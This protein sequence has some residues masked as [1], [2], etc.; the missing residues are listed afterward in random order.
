MVEAELKAKNR[1]KE[2]ELKLLLEMA[3]YARISDRIPDGEGFI[4]DRQKAIWDAA[5]CY[6]ERLQSLPGQS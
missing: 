2:I 3:K 4:T 5:R 6:Q 1:T